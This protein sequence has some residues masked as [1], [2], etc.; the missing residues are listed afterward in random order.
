[1]HVDIVET[2]GMNV[3]MRPKLKVEEMFVILKYNI[4]KS[5]EV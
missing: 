5:A 3:A 2:P 1:M 4:N